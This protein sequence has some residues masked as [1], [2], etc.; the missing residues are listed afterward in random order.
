MI[1]SD[2]LIKAG[3]STS[4]AAKYIVALN[5]TL[6]KFEIN[7]H[8]RICHFLAQILHESSELSVMIENLNYSAEGLLKIF[9]THFNAEE[10]ATFAHHP[11]AIANRAYANRMGNGD[12]NS[13]DGSRYKG[14]GALQITG[15]DNYIQYHTDS[16]LDCVAHP[17]LLELPENAIMVAGNFW[18]KHVLN[19]IADTDNILKITHAING[20]VLGLNERTILLSK[21]K[22]I[23]A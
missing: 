20:G 13:G 21:L 19:A 8:L 7:T 9:P 11:Q 4:N 16:G 12:E 5:D 1:T 15:K 18:N 14:R 23:I 17:E 22:G 10:A 2:Q 3:V 6:A